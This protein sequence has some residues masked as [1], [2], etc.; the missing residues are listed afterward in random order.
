MGIKNF[1]KGDREFSFFSNFWAFA[2][3]Y[4]EPEK[5]DKYREGL[6]RDSNK[7]WQHFC[8]G[9]D[10][11]MLDDNSTKRMDAIIRAFTM[12]EDHSFIRDF[13]DYVDRFSEANSDAEWEAF[14]KEANVL[15]DRYCTDNSWRSRK[16]K[17]MI[18]DFLLT[19]DEEMKRRRE[20]S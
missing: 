1:K 7:L 3:A 20:E 11:R 8:A 4:W 12:S 15:Y 6:L 13:S 18:S 16:R 10:G 14:I 17:H 2:Q 9:S 5:N 19:V